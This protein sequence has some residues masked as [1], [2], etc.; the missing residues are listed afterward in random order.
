MCCC[1]GRREA[2]IIAVL[3][4]SA[5]RRNYGAQEVREQSEEAK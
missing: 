5:L 2:Y 4:G 1:I 3:L